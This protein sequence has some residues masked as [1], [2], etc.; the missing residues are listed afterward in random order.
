M[1]YDPR[2]HFIDFHNS[3]KRWS[4]I[5]AHRRCGKTYALLH[6]LIYSAINTFGGKF[7]YI[8][9]LY[10][11][12]KDIAWIYLLRFTEGIRVNA[13]VAELY[14]E[15]SNGSRIRLYGVGNGD[16]SQIRGQFFHGVVLD[17]YADMHPAFFAEIIRPTLVDY[18]GWCAFCGTPKGHNHFYEIYKKSLKNSNSWFCKVLRATETG[19][20]SEEEL[21]EQR[22]Q[23][24]EYAFEQEYLC[25]FESALKGAFFGDQMAKAISDGRI[26]EVD[27]IPNVQVC[28]A[29]DLGRS[30]S[31]CIT[32]WQE[33]GGQIHVIDY[34]ENHG[35]DVE[36]YAQVVESK[37]YFY[38]K[39]YLPH[40]AKTKTLA[41]NYSVIE[42]LAKIFGIRFLEVLPIH[43]LQDG[44]QGVRNIFPRLWFDATKCDRLCEALRAYQRDWDAEKKCFKEAP[45]HNWASHP[46]DSLRYLAQAINLRKMGEPKKREFDWENPPVPTFD[47]IVR[48]SER[49][50]R[51]QQRI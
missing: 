24:D 49:A 4:C 12:A 44:I 40:D 10:S 34:Y 15:L 37:P 28:T 14:V 41:A 5:V 45:L 19:V 25:N 11:Q 35:Q 23:M 1:H 48:A 21:E 30:D 38:Q 17:E 26:R 47:E 46:A 33:V 3:S 50:Q 36:H 7:A 8:A 31:T 27:Y 9:P 32:F 18:K 39:H 20:I 29:W 42:Q 13:N 16:G 43:H 2:P 22:E 51:R 6:E